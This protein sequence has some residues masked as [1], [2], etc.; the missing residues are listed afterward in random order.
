M[1]RL[2]NPF[3]YIAGGKALTLGVIFI[4]SSSLLLYSG[5][6]I[7]DSY[8]HITNSGATYMQIL[9]VQLVWWIVPAILYYTCGLF[10]SHSR[11]RIIDVLGTTAFAQ[12]LYI[13]LIAPLHIPAI[14]E[15]T[16]ITLQA[17][18]LGLQPTLMNMTTIML[19]GIWSFAFLALYYVW[20]YKAF[21]VSCNVNGTKAIVA[22]VVIQI[23][24][25]IAGSVF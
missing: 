20:N 10:M 22:F 3:R 7:Q 6:M 2:F 19:Y 4:L 13:P 14:Q 12:L 1:E 23:V 18:S 11:I 15:A 25:T 8:V 24:M 17:V 5:G 21:S 9:L 16:N